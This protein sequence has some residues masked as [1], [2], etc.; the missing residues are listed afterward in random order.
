MNEGFVRADDLV[1]EV[2]EESTRRVDAAN[3]RID[4]ANKRADDLNADTN[5]RI[6]DLIGQINSR[7]D[8]GDSESEPAEEEG[9]GG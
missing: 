7:N 3:G 8:A 1:D 4:N 2:D 9:T 6:D 5:R